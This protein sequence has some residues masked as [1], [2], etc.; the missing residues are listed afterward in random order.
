M[1]LSLETEQSPWPA[2]F[3]DRIFGSTFHDL[4]CAPAINSASWV[5]EL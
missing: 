3:Y 2:I 1:R 4:G 5:K